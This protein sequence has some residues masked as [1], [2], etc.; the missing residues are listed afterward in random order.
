MTAYQKIEIRQAVEELRALNAQTSI[1]GIY[2]DI[3][4]ITEHIMSIAN[5]RDPWHGFV[6]KETEYAYNH[7]APREYEMEKGY[8][9]K[10]L[11]E[12]LADVMTEEVESSSFSDG[13]A[14]DLA[15]QYI[16]EVDFEEIADILLDDKAEG[17]P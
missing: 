16:E 2:E 1:Q 6:N 8:T 15:E 11:A 7:L 12:K 13:L 10:G 4:R 17:Q 3:H 5:L 9:V 14:R